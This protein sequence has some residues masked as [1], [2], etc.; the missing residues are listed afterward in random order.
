MASEKGSPPPPIIVGTPAPPTTT[1]GTKKPDTGALTPVTWAYEFL[2]Y[3]HANPSGAG[4]A[5]VKFLAA[6]I[7]VGEGIYVNNPYNPLAMEIGS[8]KQYDPNAKMGSYRYAP[9]VATFGSKDEGFQATALFMQGAAPLMWQGM[10]S[11]AVT[12]I[13][14]TNRLAA[15]GWNNGQ[16]GSAGSISYASRIGGAVGANY[17]GDIFGTNYN[18]NTVGPAGSLA[19]KHNEYTD[20]YGNPAITNVTGVEVRSAYDRIH[21]ALDNWGL[22]DKALVDMAYSRA[23]AGESYDQILLDIRKTPQYNAAFPGMAERQKAGLPPMTEAEYLST[24]RQF[25]TLATKYNLPKGFI[26]KQ[27]IGK[28]VGFSVSPLE[29]NQRLKDLNVVAQ[30]ADPLVKREFE[31]YTGTK[32]ALG[33]LTAYFADPHRAT[34]LLT[35]QL[36]A[37]EFGAQSITS[38]LGQ[39]NKGQAMELAHYEYLHTPGSGA[40]AIDNASNLGYLRASA[41]G[42]T[43]KGVTTEQLIGAQVP[44][45]GGHSLAADRGAVRA[46]ESARESYLSS[47]GGFEATSK[48][49][50]GAGSATTEGVA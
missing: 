49:V 36:N 13:E 38:G 35:E 4:D 11:S 17:T 14:L 39:L 6:W 3:I 27:E 15:T 46:A 7:A 2:N 21:L 20:R 9:A 31:K 29:F 37:A 47:G 45:F 5:R 24:E 40:T 18:K 32:N 23:M 10:M 19:V 30:Q 28:L 43:T 1:T 48:G 22:G 41:P 44:G 25:Q 42:A 50:R 33:A 8:V 12:D 34:S 26:S 16:G